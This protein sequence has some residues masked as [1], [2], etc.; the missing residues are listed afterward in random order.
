MNANVGGIDRILRIVAGLVLI[1]LDAF[2]RFNI[3]SNY[4]M[5]VVDG[6]PDSVSKSIDVP[7]ANQHAQG[8]AGSHTNL[9]LEG[10]FAPMHEEL[11]LTKAQ[12]FEIRGKKPRVSPYLSIVCVKKK[13]TRK[14]P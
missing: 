9:F 3:S 4:E 14:N 7:K 11:T 5:L 6:K 13:I 12:D 2:R 10:N 8:M 1:S